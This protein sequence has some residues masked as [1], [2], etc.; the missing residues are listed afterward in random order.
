MD[1]HFGRGRRQLA[2]SL[3]SLFRALKRE[4][5]VF[6]DPAQHFRDGSPTGIS[7]P[8]PSDLLV[9]ALRQTKTPLGRLVLVLAAAHAVPVH[10]LRTIL[11]CDL[12]PASLHAAPAPSLSAEA[13]YGTPST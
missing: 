6:R 1:G 7:K 10:E 9:N 11:T 5:V 2:L 8:V 13:S 3:R 4:R 12:R